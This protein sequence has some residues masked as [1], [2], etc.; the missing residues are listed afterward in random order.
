MKLQFGDPV[1]LLN[2]IPGTPFKKGTYGSMA[3]NEGVGE[4]IVEFGVPGNKVDMDAIFVEVKAYQIKKVG[5]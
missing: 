3:S 1:V 5:L 4:L 2:D